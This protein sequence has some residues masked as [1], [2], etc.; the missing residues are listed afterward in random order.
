[1]QHLKKRAEAALAAGRAGEA[2]SHY[3]AA[4]ALL[5]P[6]PGSAA[7]ASAA[8]SAEL[9]L[10]LSNRSAALLRAGRAEAAREDAAAAAALAPGWSKAWW[11]LGRACAALQRWPEALDA[12]VAAW[13]L[14]E[15]GSAEQRQC[16]GQ[17]VAAVRAL[18]RQQLADRLLEALQATGSAQLPAAAADDS[19]G[20]SGAALAV[21]TGGVCAWLQRCSSE[22]LREGLFQVVRQQQPRG[23]AATAGGGRQARLSPPQALVLKA[24]LL[25]ALES[26]GGRA[27][28]LL[29]AATR[30]SGLRDVAHVEL[31]ALAARLAAALQLWR[32]AQDAAAAALAA[33]RPLELAS[34]Q[35]LLQLCLE[36]QVAMGDAWAAGGCQGGEP[37]CRPAEAALAYRAA[38]DLLPP[39]G[40][41]WGGADTRAAAAA[42]PGSASALPLLQLLA[43]EPPAQAADAPA[44]RRQLQAKLAAVVERLD[45]ADQAAVWARAAATTRAAGSA[46]SRHAQ[47]RLGIAPPPPAPSADGPAAEQQHLVVAL[48][49]RSRQQS[50]RSGSAGAPLSGSAR[51]QLLGALAAAAGVGRCAVSL[52]QL[53][54]APHGGRAAAVQS[55]TAEVEFGPAAAAAAAFITG[56][57]TS[58]AAL[59]A[60][61]P[62][63]APLL[64]GAG[65]DAD[66]PAEAAGAAVAAACERYELAAQ[67]QDLLADGG[68]ALSPPPPDSAALVVAAPQ[69]T[70]EEQQHLQERA[71]HA[72][73]IALPYAHYSLVSEDG[74]PLERPEKHP[75]A[76]TRVHY[77]SRELPSAAREVWFEVADGAARWRQTAG[78]VIVQLHV[79][80][81]HVTRARQLAVSLEPRAMRVWE[82]AP[83]RSQQDADGGS[84]ASSI[85]QGFREPGLLLFEAPLARAIVPEESTWELV[86]P[87]GGA[88]RVPRQPAQAGALALSGGALA[89]VV[90]AGAATASTPRCHHLLLEL[91]K[92]NLELFTSPG[93]HGASMWPR[94]FED[95]ADV[96][97]D[98]A[99][100]DY[101]DLP[102]P[103]AAEAA[104]A[105]ARDEA[106][107]REAAAAADARRRLQDA[108]DRHQR[109]RAERLR[110]MRA[111]AWRA[112]ARARHELQLP[113]VPAADAGPL[114]A[115]A[116]AA[117]PGS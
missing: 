82:R 115:T 21:R 63:L 53:Q 1:M 15:P 9:R 37:A 3:D 111:A 28:A 12:M 55:L 58:M 38:L 31:L 47:L 93:H 70:P 86:E 39:G 98:D 25:Q 108:V 11:R 4:I 75:F 40:S 10:L 27:Q 43:S 49:I 18:T 113:R 76:L 23:A 100:K 29:A 41:G 97:W 34:E 32:D 50:S 72:G 79:L 24:A 30:A 83:E 61:G 46:G 69:Q 87:P 20:S 117:A 74:R 6:Q 103:I 16:E 88:R 13:R 64:L 33:L 84:A 73:A 106:A 107:R 66:A 91:A 85:V 81:P 54:A 92:L 89:A 48:A 14:L 116:G 8:A 42:S 45:D 57:C 105:R 35:L 80:P 94:L 2:C 51:V 26:G 65:S 96:A 52:T 59:L 60:A 56:A 110:A 17:L 95:G 114:A 62:Q 90:G 44:L 5:A 104:A 112:A 22:E 99:A 36:V 78:S 7:G 71:A 67:L 109:A 19:D 77:D 102:A 101:S 68:H